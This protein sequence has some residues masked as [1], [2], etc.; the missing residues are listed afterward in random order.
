[1]IDQ[2]LAPTLKCKWPVSRRSLEPWQF[3]RDPAPLAR[4]N[5]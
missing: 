3:Y 5:I 2:V 1:M 4:D